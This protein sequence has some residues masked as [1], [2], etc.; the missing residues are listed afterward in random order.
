MNIL[1]IQSS[2]QS[3]FPNFEIIELEDISKALDQTLIK[4]NV[5]GNGNLSNKKAILKLMLAQQQQ[6]SG[7]KRELSKPLLCET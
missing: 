4:S 6:L 5:H 1:L 3:V 7:D 2:K